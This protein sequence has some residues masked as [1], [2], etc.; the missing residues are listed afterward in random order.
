[1]ATIALAFAPASAPAA[2]M[3]HRNRA[4]YRLESPERRG[5]MDTVYVSN[6]K[7]AKALFP[8]TAGTYAGAE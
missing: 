5:A 7:I 1:V 2:P 6:F 4:S 8:D 3:P